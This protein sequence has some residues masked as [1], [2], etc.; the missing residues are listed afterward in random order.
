MLDAESFVLGCSLG[1]VQSLKGE[2]GKELGLQNSAHKPAA[3]SACKRTLMSCL[4]EKLGEQW[5]RK[6][7]IGHCKVD[8]C[9][10]LLFCAGTAVWH[11]EA[12]MGEL[13]EDGHSWFH[14][15]KK[16]SS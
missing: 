6:G 2:V 4:V 15:T 14:I 5:V 3:G 13:S 8:P 12:H 7:K 9:S 10:V 11:A 1:A 16:P